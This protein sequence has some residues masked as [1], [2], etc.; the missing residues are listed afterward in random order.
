VI[1]I[2]ALA[3]A[4]Q[5]TALPPKLRRLPETPAL[6][7]A[8]DSAI[9]QYS[10]FYVGGFNS[11]RILCAEDCRRV[12]GKWR[13]SFASWLFAPYRAVADISIIPA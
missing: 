9:T 3:A 1:E 8:A 7:T 2:P 10:P 11:C 4:V 5:R 12:R 6:Q 13:K